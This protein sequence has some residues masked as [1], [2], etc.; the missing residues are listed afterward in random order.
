M[1]NIDSPFGLR[2]IDSRKAYT[3][4]KVYIASGY[5]TNVF[6][7]DALTRAATATSNTSEVK[8]ATGTYGIGELESAIRV[9]PGAANGILGVVV[10]LDAPYGVETNY[11]LASTDRV[12]LICDDPQAEYEIQAEGTFTA[13]QVGLNAVLID[14]H[15][16][17]TTFGLSGTELDCGTGTAPAADATY[18]LTVKGFINRPDNTAGSANAKL[19][20]RINNHLNAHAIVG[21][22]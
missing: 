8:T 5:A 1:A 11:G 10:A 9:T 17:D 13:A 6:V 12:A 3:F 2:L 18:Q 7:G 21:K 22:A 14:T 15:S 16:G 19:R 4:K 20:V